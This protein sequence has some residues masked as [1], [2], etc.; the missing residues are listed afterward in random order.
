MSM[1]HSPSGSHLNRE[2]H[3]VSPRS[4]DDMHL[5]QRN[6][7]I[8]GNFT[9]AQRSLDSLPLHLKS[10][11]L[12]SNSPF[13]NSPFAGSV[14]SHS[15]VSSLSRKGTPTAN[16]LDDGAVDNVG[17]SQWPELTIPPPTSNVFGTDELTTSPVNDYYT[18]T[19]GDFSMPSAGLDIP[20]AG[21]EPSWSAGDL[22]LIPNKL[23]DSMMEP[24]SISGESNHGSGPGLT[25]ASS[26]A[27]S[28]VGEPASYENDLSQMNAVDNLLRWD[29]RVDFNA[30]AYGLPMFGLG[31]TPTSA[32]GSQSTPPIATNAPK[33]MQQP[34]NIM[35]PKYDASPPFSMTMSENPS[36]L[37]QAGNFQDADAMWR[38]LFRPTGI[39]ASQ[40]SS[41][42]SVTSP[43]YSSSSSPTSL[44][45]T[46][47]NF[48][49][50]GGKPE[51]SNLD[52]I[53]LAADASWDFA[54]GNGQTMDNGLPIPL[55]PLDPWDTETSW[56]QWPGQ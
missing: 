56:K 52:S 5:P 49:P 28:E 33:H 7:G 23:S 34:Q 12:F 18:P 36:P 21:I 9:L 47:P 11:G 22:P 40:S 10:T 31:H 41:Q 50:Q 14:Q 32:P 6:D 55:Q 30:P 38:E 2:K 35:I 4:A 48:V 44:N 17:S 43:S 27:Q 45:A 1:S 3:E 39:P 54:L 51:S 13:A 15:P 25:A 53:N 20:S 42:M 29:G 16:L 24:V 37:E 26:G 8:Y 19:D 46:A